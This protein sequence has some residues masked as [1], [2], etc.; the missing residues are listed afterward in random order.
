MGKTKKKTHQEFILEMSEKH[1]HLAILNEYKNSKTRIRYICKKCG[2]EWEATACK[3]SAGR[4]CP[5]CAGNKRKTHKEYVKEVAKINPDIEILS[6]YISTSR[7]VTFRCKKCGYEWITRPGSVLRGKGC[8]WCGKKSMAKKLT[9]TNEEFLSKLPDDRLYDVISDYKCLRTKVRCKCQKCGKE[10]EALPRTLLTGHGCPYCKT[11]KGEETIASI[12]SV[13]N[14]KYIQQYKFDE[15][16]GIGGKRLSY[17]FFLPECNTLIEYQGKQHK[18]PI[19]F[20]GGEETFKM[21]KE[22]DK[23]KRQYAFRNN[24]RL[25]EIWFYEDIET[26][27]KETLN[28]ETV[29]T[30]GGE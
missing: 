24:Y 4:G 30:A 9:T 21:Q 2:L 27:I 10:W 11:S 28:L 13:N 3:L 1:P 5:R 29:T 23:R 25:I 14:I 6:E 19:D 7:K 16:V 8:F 17:D 26:K 20:F 12:L 15:L 22:H 18:V